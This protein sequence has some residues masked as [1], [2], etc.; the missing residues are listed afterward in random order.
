[1]MGGCGGKEGKREEEK[2]GNE[3]RAEEGGGVGN[4]MYVL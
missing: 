3:Q 4:E 1:M 2:L